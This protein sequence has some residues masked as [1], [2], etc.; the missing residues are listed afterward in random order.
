MSDR[1]LTFMLTVSFLTLCA[2]T[3]VVAAMDR[4]P[5]MWLGL[6]A[7]GVSMI[8][9]AATVALGSAFLSASWGIG[10]GLIT[11]VVLKDLWDRTT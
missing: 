11:G 9:I 6:V 10:T 7:L 4:K 3:L 8:G 2:L 1:D 5:P